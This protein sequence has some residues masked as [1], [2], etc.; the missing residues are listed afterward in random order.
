M[1]PKSTYERSGTVGLW[2][3]VAID[4]TLWKGVF[5]WVRIDIVDYNDLE[6]FLMLTGEVRYPGT[7]RYYVLVFDVLGPPH[8][9]QHGTPFLVSLKW[10]PLKGHVG[11]KSPSG[12]QDQDEGIAWRNNILPAESWQIN[13]CLQKSKQKMS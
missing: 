10:G 11:S 1:A 4:V 9:A 12:V 8:L 3:G 5:K 13:N 7:L 2:K 6:S